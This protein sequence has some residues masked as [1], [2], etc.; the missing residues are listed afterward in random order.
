MKYIP[1]L[2]AASLLAA[3]NGSAKVD[4]E[5][6]IELEDILFP[7]L[8]FEPVPFTDVSINGATFSGAGC[9]EGSGSMIVSPDNKSISVLFDEYIVE[10][11]DGA[12]LVNR[13]KCDIAISLDIPQGYKAILMD[14]DYRLAVDVTEGA[15]VE[16]TRQ[17]F[18]AGGKSE[19]FADRWQGKLE[20]LEVDVPD[21]LGA[22]GGSLS[23]CGEDVI[24]RSK[25][26]LYS[27]VP[28]DGETAFIAVDSLDFQSSAQFDY[29]L[30]YVACN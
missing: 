20:N 1:L 19:T 2:L 3:C 27:S 10:S 14:A 5:I 7:D 28:H 18:F 11:G 6:E 26:S 22:Y 17:Y 13:S 30:S 9:P 25:T 24:L 8:S 23:E 16:F 4:V 29:H 15:F 12:G 21:D